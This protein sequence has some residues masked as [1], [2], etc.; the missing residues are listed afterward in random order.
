MKNL[1]FIF[2]LVFMGTGLFA[3]GAED[4]GDIMFESIILVPDMEEYP[5]LR[6]N[7]A[8]HNKKYHSTEG[9]YRAWVY[10]VMTGPNVG[11]IVWMMGPLTFADLDNRPS[12]AGHD[13][14]W[15]TNVVPYLE[16][17]EH[18]E[19]WKRDGAL[20]LPMTEETYP[21]I[22][23]RYHNIAKGQG[24]RVDALL[25]KMSATIKSMDHVTSWSLYDNQ[26]RQGL[27]TGRHIASV[28][29]MKN[30]AELD[31]EWGFGAAYN[32]LHGTNAMNGFVREMNE[33]ISNSW[34]EIWSYN[35]KLSGQE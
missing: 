13:E 34:D 15:A 8:A 26:F 17:V 35:A 21:L 1:F 33:V 32:K 30:W 6:A 9:P 7:L 25:E 20:S 10:E 4:P 29:G 27:A 24:Y 3:Q 23:I 12:D 16:K 5:T 14:D 19:Y 28:S 31:D 18:G 22:Y 11:K 2:L